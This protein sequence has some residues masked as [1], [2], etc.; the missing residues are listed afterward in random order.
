MDK[1]KAYDILGLPT[2]ANEDDIK[3]AYRELAK[4]YSPENYSGNPLQPDADSR[5]NEL[6][7]AFDTLMAYLRGGSSDS[8]PYSSAGRRGSLGQYSAIRQLVNSGRIDEA[9]A[10]LQSAPHGAAD[11]EWNFL[12]GSAYYYKGWLNQALSYFREAVRLEPSNSEYQAALRNLSGNAGG[13]M[14]G[15]PYGTPDPGGQ[16]LNCACNTCTLMCC[17]DACCSMCRGM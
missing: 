17:M 14:P 12:M 15:T 11:A 3:A 10:E 7:E 5:M 2:S 9:L 16:A 4:K 1:S 8:A 6:N 13:E